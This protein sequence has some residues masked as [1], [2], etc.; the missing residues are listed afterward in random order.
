VTRPKLILGVLAAACVG[1]LLWYAWLIL[2]ADLPRG[3]T[4]ATWVL[5]LFSAA[6]VATL[7]AYVREFLAHRAAVGREASWKPLPGLVLL[8]LGG[9]TAMASFAFVLPDRA[10]ADGADDPAV[11]RGSLSAP[12][13]DPTSGV[14]DGARSTTTTSRSSS[15]RTSPPAPVSTTSPRQVSATSS[16]SGG[17]AGSSTATSTSSPTKTRGNSGHTSTG[18]PTPSS[19]TN[20]PLI[21]I[22]LPPPPR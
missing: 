14:A 7:L 17:S 13:G 8:W 10:T 19:T 1:T 12:Q 9:L 4:I 5:W 18:K 22:T 2:A 16:P 11:T 15:S 6:A 3:A 21:V 20:P